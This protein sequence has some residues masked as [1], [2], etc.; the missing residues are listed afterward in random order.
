VA[1]LL[2]YNR[3]H[4]YTLPRRNQ[5]SQ[6]LASIKYLFNAA[7]Q[8]IKMVN[9]QLTEQF[10]IETNHAHSFWGLCIH[11]YAKLTAYTLYGWPQCRVSGIFGANGY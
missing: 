9:G 1:D 11:L 7:R 2:G 10:N 5:K 8:I 4:L 3:T 6:L